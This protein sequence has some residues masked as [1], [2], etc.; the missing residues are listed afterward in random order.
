LSHQLFDDAE[1]EEIS[2]RI[3]SR[4]LF[5]RTLFT[6]K[7]FRALITEKYLAR[8]CPTHDRTTEKE[9]NDDEK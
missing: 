4:L 1:E 9:E 7:D 3:R 6:D 8:L 5:P 2:D